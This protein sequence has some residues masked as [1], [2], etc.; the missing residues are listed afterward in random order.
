MIESITSTG[1]SP[2]FMRSWLRASVE[3]NAAMLGLSCRSRSWPFSHVFSLPPSSSALIVM[4]CEGSKSGIAILPLRSG[5]Q[6]SAHF[7]IGVFT[8]SA[9]YAIV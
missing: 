2:V 4:M 6:R 9:R 8:W 7:V 1:A 5:R 3:K